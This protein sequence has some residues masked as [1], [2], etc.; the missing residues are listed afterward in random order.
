ME[1][2]SCELLFKTGLN[3]LVSWISTVIIW[4]SQASVDP[5]EPRSILK[6]DQEVGVAMTKLTALQDIESKLPGWTVAACGAPECNALAED[7]ILGKCSIE[8]CPFYRLG[9]LIDESVTI[10]CL[11]SPYERCVV[12]ED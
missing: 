4:I 11:S 12:R 1:Q 6:L 9:N 3:L 7:I 10:G 5:I 8:Q 2:R